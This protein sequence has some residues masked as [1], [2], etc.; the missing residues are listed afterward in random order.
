MEGGDE[1]VDA[2]CVACQFRK[3]FDTVHH[4]STSVGE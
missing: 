4:A 1:A 2:G 3:V